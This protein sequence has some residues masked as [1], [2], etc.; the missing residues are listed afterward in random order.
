MKKLCTTLIFLLSLMQ[1]FAQWTND[2][3]L[4]TLVRDTAGAT[5]P[6][7]ASRTDGSSYI[8]WFEY[9]NTGNFELR[10]Q[11]LDSNGYARWAPGGIV[12][13][14]YPQN[15]ALFRY[16]LQTDNDGNAIVAFQDERTGVL[17]VVAYKVTSTGSLAWGVAGVAL[18]DSL[19]QEGLAPVIGIAANNDVVIA[20]NANASSSK[21]ITA[22]RLS[23][24]G[25][26]QWNIL[27]RVR[28]TVGS[29][30]YSRP[31]LLPSGPDGILM[32][33]VEENGSFPGV[34]STL[35]AQRIDA[36]GG[37]V[38]PS[39]VMVSSKTIPYFIFPEPVGDGAGG[40]YVAFD[41][42]NPVNL[43]LNDVY[44]QHVDSAGNLWSVTGTEAANSTVNHKLA[45]ASCYV[46]SNGEF[47]VLLRVL[48]GGQSISGVSVQKFDGSGN[49]L[50]G[51][52][53][54]VIVAMDASLYIPNTIN[55]V[56]DGIIFS[57][58]TGNFA[59]QH[60]MA[61]KLDY[62]GVA[63]WPGMQVSLCAVNSNKDDLASGR[64]VNN[65]L[66]FAWQDD[67]NGSGVFAQNVTGDGNTGITTGTGVSVVRGNSS[68]WPNPSESPHLV[69]HGTIEKISLCDARGSVI[70]SFG[71]ASE[72]LW[73]PE[74]KTLAPGI[75]FF[76][77]ENKDHT[78]ILRW[79][80]T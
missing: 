14:N 28:D 32:L 72:D 8:S 48:D 59:N 19:A 49:P 21:W 41:S 35:Y 1:S 25:V 29:L 80:K 3:T 10:M 43:A 44:V 40:L 45:A 34:T 73:L 51:P 58:Q 30:K 65:N 70:R 31:K 62:N 79:I 75:Y 68:V 56:Q 64:F 13:S 52:D 9:D 66:V 60:V 24:A 76:L 46:S 37:S 77:L 36:N 2:T 74:L 47:W 57:C 18:T 67:R 17:N 23:P 54:L 11:L 26:P 12:V 7:I 4:N 22:Q 63:V 20:W 16:D 55:D 33:F 5:T 15:S 42:S 50:L 27:Y 39:A 61:V 53:A 69:L 78:Q 6:L 71:P 38:W